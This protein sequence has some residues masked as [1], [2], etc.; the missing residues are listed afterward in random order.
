[1][2]EELAE[3]ILEPRKK[4]NTQLARQHLENVTE[5]FEDLVRQAN[6]DAAENK[7]TCAKIYA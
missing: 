2:S 3:D 6:V 5:Y 1:M 4:Y 7:A